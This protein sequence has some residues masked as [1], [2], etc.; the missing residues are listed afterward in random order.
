MRIMEA[1]RTRKSIRA[2][3]ATPVPKETLKELLENCLRA[4]SWG[5]TQPWEFA[6]LGGQV[7]EELKQRLVA[8]VASGT[9]GNPDIPYPSFP[10]PYRDRSGANGKRLFE[11]LG[12]D[13]ENREQRAQWSQRMF[14]F[15]DAPNG[16]IFYMD[17]S[18][19]LWSILDI[20]IFLQTVMLAALNYG[21]GTC[22]EAAVVAYPEEL[23]KMLGI[24]ESKQFICGMAIGYPDPDAPVNKLRSL[25]EPLET[26]A[27]WHGLD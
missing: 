15:F 14:R 7:M 17:K 2:Y 11:V 18:L 16:I 21:L 6:I 25:R 27:T 1:I 8:K 23:R 10:E 26:F 5:D 19:G 9:R 12:I 20:G 24:P 4:P 13:R 3:K 22:P